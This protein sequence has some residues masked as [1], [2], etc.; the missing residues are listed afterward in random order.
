VAAAIGT[1]ALLAAGVTACSPDRP[2]P[3]PAAAAMAS[4]LAS[5]DFAQVPL[6]E[7]APEPAA[8][9][10]AR[11]TAFAGLGERQPAVAVASVTVDEEDGSR[12]QAVL[13]WVWEVGADEAWS[14]D[15]RA[16]LA[17]VEGAG[18]DAPTWRVGWR[19]GLL[20]PDLTDGEVLSLARVRAERGTILGGDGL[21]IVE[22]RPVWRVG[23]DK[24][25]VEP[26]GQEGAAVALASTLG[27]DPTAY[28]QRVAAAGPKAFVEAIVVRDGDPEYDVAALQA[29]LGVNAVADEL[30]LAPTRRFARPILG[31]AGQ[32]TAEI[33]EGSGGAVVAG[34]LTGLSG[35]QRQYDEQLRGQPGIRVEATAGPVTRVLFSSEPVPGVPLQTTLDTR[36][37]NSAED[38]LAAVGPAA[39]IVALRPSTGEVL[40]AAS[41]P[42]SGG[43]STATVGQYPPGSTFKVVGALGLLRAGLTPDSTVQCP[44]T[45][46][47]D[48]RPFSN[49]PGY[50]ATALG[51]I[52]LRAAFANSCNTAFIGQRD[53]LDQAG[54]AQAARSLGLDPAAE[55]GFPAFLGDVPADSTGTDHAASLIGQGRVLASPLGMA[56]VAA[57]VAAGHTVVPVLVRPAEPAGAASSGTETGGA[58]PELT[59]PEADTLRGLMRAVVTDGGAAFLQDVP[60]PEVYAKTGT[61]Q[62]QAA[63][64]LANHVWMIAIHGDLAVAVFVETGDYGSTTA[65]PLLEQFL[66]TAG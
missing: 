3:A 64:G 51:E 37:Q 61:A 63:E 12:A 50:P 34:D 53:T 52:P 43:L 66:R 5:G 17:L 62:Y 58:A 6:A 45:A 40:A 15:V 54:L 33:I 38:V 55:L 7:G 48:G 22:P 24:T 60:A 31:Q 44:P 57:S 21:V 16:D 10:T 56:A 49:F 47:V 4:A 8:L 1:F 11:Q 9:T 41:G 13:H 32:A 20:A 30:P 27:M 65:G 18:D 29:I 59:S 35:L 19:P 28:A 36:L 46:T 25:R 39:A 14:Y 42:G 2:E 26:A 23:I